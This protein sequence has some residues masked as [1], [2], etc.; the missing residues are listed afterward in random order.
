MNIKIKPSNKNVE[1]ILGLYYVKEEYNVTPIKEETLHIF[2]TPSLLKQYKEF[3]VYLLG[4]LNNYR[5]YF[6]VDKIRKIIY[7]VRTYEVYASLFLRKDISALDYIAEINMSFSLLKTLLSYIKIDGNYR[8]YYYTPIH[9]L[10]REKT[11][12]KID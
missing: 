11:V 3:D 10:N 6:I 2:S 1:N 4:Y 12:F 5:T 8:I 7:N 9:A